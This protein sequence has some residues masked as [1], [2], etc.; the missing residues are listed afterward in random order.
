MQRRTF[1]KLM[2]AT[3]ATASFGGVAFAQ[4][5]LKPVRFAISS[6]APTTGHA[7]LASIPMA[8]GYF[9]E[10]G[11]DFT[12]TPFAGSGD[13]FNH[14]IAGDVIAADGGTPSAYAAIAAGQD[15]TMFFASITGN[16]YYVAAPDG[17]A[18]TKL[19][20]FVGKTIGV[21]SLSAAGLTLFKA[22]MVAEGLDPNSIEYIAMPTAAEAVDQIRKGRIAA[23]LA[24]D[25]SY[26]Q[27]ESLGMPTHRVD[28]KSQEKLGFLAG[29][30]VKRETLEKD[31]DTLIKLGRSFAK[32]VVFAKENPEAAVRL[33]WKVFPNTKPLGQSEEEAMKAGLLSV[34]A[35]FQNI[36]QVDGLYGNATTDQVQTVLD[37]LRTGDALLKDLTP[38]QVWTGELIAEINKFDVEAVKRQAREWKE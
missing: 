23:Y 10:E 16:V 8:M 2:L 14:V 34:K 33:T 20:D 17:S 12:L 6:A 35:R 32:G 5:G 31:R 9:V 25:I 3:A 13:A 29:S 7:H 4:Q 24:F 30:V 18:I 11:L 21:Y 27:M 28:V 19:S 22:S 37:L 26:A 38:E 36:D 15:L 1:A